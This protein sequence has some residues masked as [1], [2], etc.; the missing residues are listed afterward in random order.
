M[1]SS[2]TNISLQWFPPNCTHLEMTSYSPLVSTGFTSWPQD[3][4]YL[5]LPTM[6]LP[7]CLPQVPH[8]GTMVC[9]GYYVL[10]AR[11]PGT[12]ERTISGVDRFYNNIV[13]LQCGANIDLITCVVPRCESTLDSRRLCGKACPS[14]TST[15]QLGNQRSQ[16]STTTTVQPATLPPMS[17]SFF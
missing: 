14:F 12:T 6:V 15:H 2:Q 4:V 3:Q 10:Y 7:A 16:H 17:M 11:P 8:D 1:N 13:P 5:H 9:S